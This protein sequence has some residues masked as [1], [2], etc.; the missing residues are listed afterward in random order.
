MKVNAYF[1]GGVNGVG[2]TTF[3]SELLSRDKRF[4]LFKG[5]FELMKRLGL[6]EGDYRPLKQFPEDSFK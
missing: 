1:I 4:K 5:S 2:K 3:M 6:N